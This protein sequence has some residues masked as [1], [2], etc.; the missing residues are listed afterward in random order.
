MYKKLK[1]LTVLNLLTL[2]SLLIFAEERTENNYNRAQDINIKTCL[3]QDSNFCPYIEADIGYRH[4]NI[5]NTLELYDALW[6]ITGG[7]RQ[8]VDLMQ[9][10]F[11]AGALIHKY[12]FIKG[13]IGYAFVNKDQEAEESFL[14]GTNYLVNS[15]TKEFNSG[16][17]FDGLIGGGARI[18]IIDDY[19]ALDAELGYDYRKISITNSL[20]TRVSSPYV[21]GTLYGAL[22]WNLQLTIYGS[23]FFA[24]AAK[25]SGYLYLVTSN[26]FTPAPSFHTHHNISAY[27]VG[28]NL[29]YMFTDHISLNLNWERFS[30]STGFENGVFNI[31]IL[32]TIV[33]GDFQAKINHWISNQFVLGFRYSF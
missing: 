5:N 14:K 23:Y 31:P 26:S 18:P 3:C 19:L 17:A 28:S 6:D 11:R 25:E 15:Y 12:V 10:N 30:A 8:R 33:S 32:G 1:N 22:G 29:S 16:H 20:T 9:L 24:P 2:S 21:G 13:N 4:D 27:K 7:R